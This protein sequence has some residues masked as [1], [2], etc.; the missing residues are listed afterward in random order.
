MLST[1]TSAGQAGRP[2]AA[3]ARAG[4]RH[5]PTARRARPCTH[6]LGDAVGAVGEGE[7]EFGHPPQEHR[8]SIRGRVAHHGGAAGARGEQPRPAA[9][10]VGG[11]GGG[12]GRRGE[13]RSRAQQRQPLCEP[14]CSPHAWVGS[15]CTD[16]GSG[17]QTAL[18]VGGAADS[19][20]RCTG[21]GAA[22]QAL[23]RSV[24]SHRP[25][26]NMAWRQARGT[27]QWKQHRPACSCAFRARLSS[28]E[29]ELPLQTTGMQAEA[30]KCL[31]WCPRAN[32]RLQ[33]ET[34]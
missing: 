24:L 19:G 27:P 18:W 25:I 1:V 5:P 15:C 16:G 33:A 10:V 21:P 23:D 17:V 34:E 22:R 13:Q 6:A 12:G 31:G 8:P 4:M 20:K 14:G 7:P 3:A 11:V 32:R 28:I 29:C 26:A 9:E 2:W 30:M